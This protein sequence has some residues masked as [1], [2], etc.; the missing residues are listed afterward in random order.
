[1]LLNNSYVE[2]VVFDVM[3]RQVKTL[4]SDYML[5][6]S[7]LVTWDGKSGNGEKVPSGVYIYQLISN[8]MIIS[9]RMTL[10]K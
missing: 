9:K 7:H 3:G 1:M 5:E 8:D 6:G 2:L 4:I 10:L